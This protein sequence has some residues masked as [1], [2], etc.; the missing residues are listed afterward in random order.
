MFSPRCPATARH[1]G[2]AAGS[3]IAYRDV[4]VPIRAE[5]SETMASGAFE[6]TQT[7]QP[8]WLLDPQ[9]SHGFIPRYVSATRVLLLSL[10][11]VLAPSEPLEIFLR[12]EHLD[13]QLEPVCDHHF[14][15]LGID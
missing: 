8:K 10:V 14:R 12:V 3:N 1:R 7:P 15:E 9:Q 6:R 13:L 4:F 2:Q 5:L 11:C